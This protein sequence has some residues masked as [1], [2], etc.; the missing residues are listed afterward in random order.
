MTA[1][2]DQ[3]IRE[4]YGDVVVASPSEKSK[5]DEIMDRFIPDYREFDRKAAQDAPP[6]PRDIFDRVPTGF[7]LPRPITIA[8]SEQGRGFGTYTFW[9]EP[10]GWGPIKC[11]NECDSRATVKRML[12][13][14]VDASCFLDEGSGENKVGRDRHSEDWTPR[15]A[16]VSRRPSSTD[17]TAQHSQ[18]SP[19][20]EAL[21]ARI[22][23]ALKVESDDAAESRMLAR[24][25]EAFDGD[26][27]SYRWTAEA[28]ETRR[29]LFRDILTA[30]KGAQ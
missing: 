30:L 16:G 25:A 13:G 20:H 1:K 4:K 27:S 12:C 26:P 8:W 22:E 14:L 15:E 28:Q 2:S 10:N 29:D 21:I 18:P 17:G 24:T 9:Q 11:D 6:A 7:T 23:A 3:R 19:A 5:V